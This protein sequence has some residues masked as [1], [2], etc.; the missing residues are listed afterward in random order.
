MAEIKKAISSRRGYRAHLTKILQGV[1]ELLRSE[2]PPTEGDTIVLQD[3]LDQLQ[4]KEGLISA[5]DANILE[6]LNNDDKIEAEVLQTEEVNSLITTAKAKITHYLTPRA[7]APSSTHSHRIEPREHSDTTTRLPKLDLPRFSGS[8]IYWQPFWD[9]FEAA[10]DT[11]R[12]LTG[13]QKLGY[14]RAQLRGEARDV[15]AGFQLTNAS[16]A[17]SVQLR[18]DLVSPINRLTCTCRPLLISPAQAILPPVCINFMTQLRAISAVSQHWDGLKIHM[19]AC[20][21]QSCSGKSQG[22]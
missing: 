4:C 9:F 5:L 17:D 6:S 1:D 11:N 12:S 18:S 22:K 3:T 20:L 7:A 10:V 21:P 14:L 13:V 15:I 8:P 19:V 16:Y 2:H